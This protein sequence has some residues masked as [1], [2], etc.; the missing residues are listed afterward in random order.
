MKKKLCLLIPCFN[1]EKRIDVSSV[2]DHLINFSEHDILFINDG[3]SDGTSQILNQLK[4]EYQN[5]KVLDLKENVGK[6][7]A[8]LEGVKIIEHEN[9]EYIG[10][11]DADFAT[12]L[13][14]VQNF[15]EVFSKRPISKVV[16]GLRLLRLGT[17]IKRSFLRHYLGRIFA[18]GVSIILNLPIYD[19]QCGAKIFTKD[20]AKIVFEKKFISSW[21]FDVEI[22]FRI[23]NHFGID[24]EKSIIYE[25]PLKSWVDVDGSKLKKS[26]FLLA[27]FEL[28]KIFIKYKN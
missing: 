13:S 25:L 20:V 24:V 27:P 9:Y 6:A 21:F 12:P 8:I 18:T 22:L 4:S 16:T 2:K 19:S 7:Q 3:S 11:W 26:D 1:E 10:Y 23:K 5:C 28:I 17:P 15:M 14:E